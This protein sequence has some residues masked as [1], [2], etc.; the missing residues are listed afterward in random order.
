MNQLMKA[1]WK[2]VVMGHHQPKGTDS[3]EA[4]VAPRDLNTGGR[5]ALSY[6]WSLVPTFEL[7]KTWLEEFM[8]NQLRNFRM[9]SAA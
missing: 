4:V 2:T 9:N 7:I 3:K 1:N 5:Y 6:L 8:Q